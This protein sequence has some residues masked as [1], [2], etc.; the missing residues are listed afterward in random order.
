MYHHFQRFWLMALVCLLSASCAT[1]PDPE[2]LA[3]A[4][5]L[6]RALS[7]GLNTSL[8]IEQELKRLS[9][10]EPDK[11]DLL[12]QAYAGLTPDVIQNIAAPI[13]ARYLTTEELNEIADFAESPPGQ[14]FVRSSLREKLSGQTESD[15]ALTR[16]MNVDDLTIAARFGQSDVFKTYTRQA[17]KIKNDLSE[18]Y[19]ELLINQLRNQNPPHRN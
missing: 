4:K 17:P 8:S 7:L 9:V 19:Q 16:K 12:M 15:D 2:H 5:R 3:A 11:A 14:L 18:A 10:K 13:Y 6:M 1:T